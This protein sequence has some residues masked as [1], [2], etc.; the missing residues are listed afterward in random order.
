MDEIRILCGAGGLGGG[1]VSVEAIA[2]AMRRNPHYIVADAGTT[3]SGPFSLGS[4]KSNYPRESIK[5]DLEILILAAHRAGIPFLVGSS[6]TAGL[7][8]HVDMFMEIA[9]EIATENQ[10]KLKAAGIYSEQSKEYVLDLYKKGRIRELEPAPH[11]DEDVILSNEHIVGMMGVEPLQQALSEGAQIIIGG[12]TSDS[13]LY[14]AIPIMKGFPEGLAWHAGKVMECG[15]QVCVKAGSGAVFSTLR[16]DHFVLEVFGENLQVTPQS[17]AAHSFY[18]NSDPYIHE[19]SSGAMDLTNCVYTPAANGGVKVSGSAFRHRDEYTVKLEGAIKVGYQSVV[20]GGIR[21]PYFI[22][23]FDTWLENCRVAIKKSVINIL[24]LTID[25]DYKLVFH[26]Y[27]RNGVM[28]ELEPISTMPHEICLI[29]E[30]TAQS[31]ETANKIAAISRQP[32]LHQPIPEWKGSITSI[33]FLDNPSLLERGPVYRFSLNHVAIPRTKT[34]M[35]RINHQ[36][37]G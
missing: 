37:I 11:I 4:G 27:G 14:A 20:I 18:E 13:A 33:A 24:K 9:S 21:D 15:P 34:E 10:I 7:D 8:M 16:K 31:Q 26:E 36:T 32:L 35:F 29:L 30:V 6:G 1:K 23:N 2:E 5:R 28:K 19:E 22:R 12:R 3:D 25:K 17:V